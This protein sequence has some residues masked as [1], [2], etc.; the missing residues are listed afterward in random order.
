M[1]NNHCVLKHIDTV[2]QQVL[3]ICTNKVQFVGLFTRKS[4]VQLR[5]LL[6]ISKTVSSLLSFKGF[7]A[8]ELL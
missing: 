2:A 6:V 5:N 3:M 1:A 4:Q 8:I 7:W